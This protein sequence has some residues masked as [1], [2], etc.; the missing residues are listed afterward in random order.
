MYE[1]I[2]AQY[3]E[4][5]A[6]TARDSTLF[7]PYVDAYW[8]D[9]REQANLGEIPPP[10]VV[11]V[12]GS[13][14]L[15][16]VIVSGEE[17]IVLFDRTLIS[18]LRTFSLI[19]CA[20]SEDDAFLMT[21]RV[22]EQL[23]SKRL[24][25]RGD[26]TWSERTKACSWVLMAK[27][28]PIFLYSRRNLANAETLSRIQCEFMLAHELA[29]VALML[30]PHARS[31]RLEWLKNVDQVFLDGPNGLLWPRELELG[32]F[33]SDFLLEE[34]MCD[35]MA[36]V[37][38]YNCTSYPEDRGTGSQESY[39]LEDAIGMTMGLGIM[40]LLNSLDSVVES[41]IDRQGLGV[42]QRDAMGRTSTSLR[43][44]IRVLVANKFCSFDI[45]FNTLM[46]INTRIAERLIR[47]VE[48]AD[49]RF[50]YKIAQD[51]AANELELLEAALSELSDDRYLSKVVRRDIEMKAA[52]VEND[53]TS[54]VVDL[55]ADLVSSVHWADR[56]KAFESLLR[57]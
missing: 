16:T 6:T 20:T 23:G 4:A 13:G 10:R 31:Q 29:H 18:A 51:V 49:G 55:T 53:G 52:A 43:F 28:D 54:S 46:E 26:R 33:G 17:A 44:L 48:C 7:S 2:A 50:S 35:L 5:I 38:H 39:R 32:D 15:P 34:V 9:I 36:F 14:E 45:A 57:P 11:E 22:L 21:L 47:W 27:M 8:K 40:A 41:S 1:C 12:T 30:N 37:S 3:G 42:S 56:T 19:V 24:W 25:R